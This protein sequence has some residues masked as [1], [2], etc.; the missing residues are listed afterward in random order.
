MRSTIRNTPTFSVMSSERGMLNVCLNISWKVLKEKYGT[1]HTMEYHPKK[2]NL[3]V[4]FDCGAEFR[5]HSLNSELLQGPYLTSSL[6]GVLTRFRQEPVAIMADIQ[7]MFHQVKVAQDDRDFLSFLWW[8]EGNSDQ[9]LVEYRMTA[10]VRGSV[11]SQ[12][13]LLRSTK[14]CRRQPEQFL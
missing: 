13:C 9:E 10:S 14:D 12:L 7:S 6:L 1:F 4:V 5:G 11:I 8:P 3:C 2:G